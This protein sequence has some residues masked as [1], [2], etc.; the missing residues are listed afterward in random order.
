[1]DT[2]EFE[3]ERYCKAY[4]EQGL[5]KKISHLAKKGC[6]KVVYLA[7]L[8]YYVLVSEEVGMKEKAAIIGALGYLIFP[9]D[10]I[11]DFIPM[12]GYTDDFAAMV[13]AY[14]MIKL[15]ITPAIRAKAEEKSRSLFG[16]FDA[17]KI[18]DEIKKIEES[19]SRG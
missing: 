2:Q 6:E 1:M 5:W 10:L 4:S 11:P 8:L 16:D 19:G 7:L 9:V 14:Q 13:A 12:A 17:V 15:C 18:E 3:K